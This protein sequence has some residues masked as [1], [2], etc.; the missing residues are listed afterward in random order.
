MLLDLHA[1]VRG[2]AEVEPEYRPPFEGSAVAEPR[3]VRVARREGGETATGALLAEA[4]A[5]LQVG[6][7]RHA[8]LVAVDAVARPVV[9]R[10]T[11]ADADSARYDALRAR[12]A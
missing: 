5:G 1:D 6:Q 7:P 2:A 10:C 12:S 9:R 3:A 8:A 4:D 11:V